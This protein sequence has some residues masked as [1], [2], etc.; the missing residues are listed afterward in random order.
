MALPAIQFP[1]PI[2]A[3]ALLFPRMC[4]MAIRSASTRERRSLT[5]C[6]G[7][8]HQSGE[9][10]RLGGA[11]LLSRFVARTGTK[12]PEEP[13]QMPC[14]LSGDMSWPFIP[15]PDWVGTKVPVST[16]VMIFDKYTKKIHHRVVL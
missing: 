12:C 16:S 2:E 4:V 8:R 1:K 6:P 10:R 13:G 3:A 11:D 14:L 15:A 5:F 7:S 9:K